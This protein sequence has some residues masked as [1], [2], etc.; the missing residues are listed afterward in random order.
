MTEQTEDR[1]P[2]YTG[3][4][5]GGAEEVAWNH[6]CLALGFNDVIHLDEFKKIGPKDYTWSRERPNPIWSR[7]DRFYITPDIQQAGGRHGIWPTV[8]HLSDHAPIFLQLNLGKRGPR[9]LYHLT[10]RCWIQ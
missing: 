6:Y 10:R 8:A 2:G 3:K 5:M 1:S 4:A 7:L 9:D